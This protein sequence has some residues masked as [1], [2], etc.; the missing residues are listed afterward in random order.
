MRTSRAQL[1]VSALALVLAGASEARATGG[2]TSNGGDPIVYRFEAA[3]SEAVEIVSTM[4]RSGFGADVEPEIVRFFEQNREALAADIL[5][6][7]HVWD[8]Q[9]L[10]TCAATGLT[11]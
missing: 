2:S 8:Q 9:P 7:P 11:R 4:T 10:A 5:A 6:T 1:S 3:R